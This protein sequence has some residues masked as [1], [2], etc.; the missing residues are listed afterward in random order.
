ME[1]FGCPDGA[2]VIKANERP[3]VQFSS[4][5]MTAGEEE[6]FGKCTVFH[7]IIIMR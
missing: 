1:W 4:F 6:L 5:I 3:D 2:K 7:S